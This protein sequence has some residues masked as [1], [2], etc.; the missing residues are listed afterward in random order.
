[1]ANNVI[2]ETL[3]RLFTNGQGEKADRLLLIQESHLGAAQVTEATYLGGY[4][5]TAVQRIIQD[6]ADERVR[7]AWKSAIDVARKSAKKS[8]AA[9]LDIG[10]VEIAIRRLE[11]AAA[12]AKGE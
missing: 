7:E 1:M 3:D 9:G 5:R 6:I 10:A 8:M 4:N 12:E 11:I 2:A